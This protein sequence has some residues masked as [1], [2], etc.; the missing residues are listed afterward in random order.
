MSVVTLTQDLDGY[1]LLEDRELWRG[2]LAGAAM[3]GWV[4]WEGLKMAARR[5]AQ[6]N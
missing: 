5:R 1:L 4:A 6:G 3:R 2:K